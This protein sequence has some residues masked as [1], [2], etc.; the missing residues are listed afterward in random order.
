MTTRPIPARVAPRRSWA[1]PFVR[2]VGRASASGLEAA[3]PRAQPAPLSAEEDL[4]RRLREAG[5]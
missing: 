3:R 4:L 5:L 1:L 2:A